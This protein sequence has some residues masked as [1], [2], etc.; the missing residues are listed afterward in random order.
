MSA[1]KKE[2]SNWRV[3]VDLKS[4]LKNP[5]NTYASVAVALGYRDS[6]SV[7]QWIRR[8]RIPDYQI[9]RV[10]QLIKGEQQ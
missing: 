1:M 3:V 10:K 9:E 4:W 2:L 7:R 5:G 8:G 6:A